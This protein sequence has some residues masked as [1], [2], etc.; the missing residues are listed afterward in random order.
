M[1]NVKLYKKGENS[2]RL[3]GKDGQIVIF[4]EEGDGITMLVF[5]DEHASEPIAEVPL[6]SEAPATIL[7]L[8]P[9]KR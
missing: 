8:Y 4:T 7:S 6:D 9:L 2:I 3:N 5:K 1:K